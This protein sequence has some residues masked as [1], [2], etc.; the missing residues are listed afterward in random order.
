MGCCS[1]K[2]HIASSAC[3]P[4]PPHLT[5][6]PPPEEETVKEVL[7][8]VPAPRPPISAI[9]DEK[10]WG[11]RSGIRKTQQDELRIS[12]EKKSPLANAEEVSEASE[13]CSLSETTLSAV[14]EKRDDDDFGDVQKWWGGRRPGSGGSAWREN[15]RRGG[16]NRVPHRV[17]SG[18]RPLKKC[19]GRWSTERGGTRGRSP[20]EDQDRRRPVSRRPE[21][22]GLVLPGANRPGKPGNLRVGCDLNC[23]T[24]PARPK[25]ATER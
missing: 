18:R 9:G 11:P 14:P 1:S 13:I 12:V 22:R 20:G 23:R 17:G 3:Q 6:A 8:E 7:S 5:P 10:N 25:R 19:V 2:S 24:R 16:P 15:R 21:Q 4:Q